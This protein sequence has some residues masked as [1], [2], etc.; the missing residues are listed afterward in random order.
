VSASHG[1]MPGD[2]G[3]A[4]G[5]GAFEGGLCVWRRREGNKEAE[6]LAK[7]KEKEEVSEKT[8][9]NLILLLIY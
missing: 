2:D 5:A 9:R 8:E 7:D 6:R 3:E 1:R 4:D